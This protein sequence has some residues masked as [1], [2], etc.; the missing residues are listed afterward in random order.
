[1]S[2][3][4]DPNVR[5][6]WTFYQERLPKELALADGDVRIRNLSGDRTPQLLGRISISVTGLA[7]W[8]NLWPENS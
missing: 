6:F 7:E 1:M 8:K 4:Q 5:A 2:C 3:R